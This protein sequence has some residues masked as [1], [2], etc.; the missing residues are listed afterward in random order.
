MCAAKTG[1]V[2]LILC[3]LIIFYVISK[4]CHETVSSGVRVLAI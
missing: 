4:G 3:Y 2:A 1:N